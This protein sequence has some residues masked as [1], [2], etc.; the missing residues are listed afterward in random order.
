MS[1]AKK[2]NESIY[3]KKLN[4]SKQVRLRSIV[5]KQFQIISKIYKNQR[6]NREGE[7]KEAKLS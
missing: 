6:V 4:N 5:A 3:K 7:K 2:N 1:H